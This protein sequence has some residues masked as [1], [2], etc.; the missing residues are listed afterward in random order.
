MQTY[1]PVSRRCRAAD[2]QLPKQVQFG[3]QGN[4]GIALVALRNVGKHACRLTGRVRVRLVHA[5]PPSQVQK[6]TPRNTPTFPQVTYPASSLLALQPGQAGVVTVTWNNWCDPQVKGKT[7]VPPSGI[8]VTLP[9]GGGSVIG[10]YNAVPSC[11]DPSQPSVL[12]VSGFQPGLVPAGKPWTNALIRATIP[13]TPLSTRRGGVLHFR[14]VLENESSSAARFGRCPAYA[15]QL[16]PAGRIQVYSLNCRGQK[17]PAHGK[18]AFAMRIPVPRNAPIG[19]NG[20]FWILDAFGG[21]GPELD[22]RANVR[23]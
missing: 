17:I 8:R 20:L 12:G 5:V 1:A 13:D 9:A 15:E 22:V 16:A 19:H 23:G 10:N 21:Q 2:L 6:P 14:V 18:L 11:I 4:G 3:P 7:R